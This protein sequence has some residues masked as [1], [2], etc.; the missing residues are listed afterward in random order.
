MSKPVTIDGVRYEYVRGDCLVEFNAGNERRVVRI[1]HGEVCGCL[2]GKGFADYLAE[3]SLAHWRE[4]IRAH[5]A[6]D[7]TNDEG[8]ARNVTPE[9]YHGQND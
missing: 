9:E 4:A 3:G 5:D 6:C 8:I 1:E 7:G 2:G